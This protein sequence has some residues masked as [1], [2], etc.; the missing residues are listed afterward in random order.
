M[1]R[2]M[3]IKFR[4][5]GPLILSAAFLTAFCASC[6]VPQNHASRRSPD[7]AYITYTPSVRDP[8][9][10]RLAV[11]DLID[12]KGTVTTAGSAYFAKNNPPA[13]QAAGTRIEPPVSVPKATSADPFAT[14]TAEPLDDPPGM[15][16]CLRLTGFFGVPK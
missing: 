14:A 1:A 3:T 8:Q 10:I 6:T 9:R 7:H 16:R 2:W 4:M 12:V 15:M 11:K 13:Q 5:N